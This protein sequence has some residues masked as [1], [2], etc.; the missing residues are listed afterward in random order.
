MEATQVISVKT[1]VGELEVIANATVGVTSEQP[2]S[3]YYDDLILYFKF[4]NDSINLTSRIVREFDD[5]SLTFVLINFNNSLGQ[6]IL[7]PQRLGS[8]FNRELFVSFWCWTPSA[9]D[10]S[11]RLLS[12]TLLLGGAV[13]E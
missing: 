10:L 4:K 8:A 12:S 9:N 7:L 1:L 5:K 3:L 6:G 11:G 2:L 13:N